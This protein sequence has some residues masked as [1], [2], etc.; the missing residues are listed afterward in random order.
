MLQPEVDDKR[1]VLHVLV[2]NL[3]LHVIFLINFGQA[4]DGSK[5]RLVFK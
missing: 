5:L 1:V 2:Q 4:V 3:H